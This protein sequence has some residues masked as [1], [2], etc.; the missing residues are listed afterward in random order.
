VTICLVTDRRRLAAGRATLA[1]A[2]ACLAAQARFAAEAGVDLVQVRER[3]LDAADLAAVVRDAIAATRGSRTRVVVNDRLDVALTCGADGVHLRGDSMAVEAARRIAPSGFL[4]GRSVH[5]IE[6][7]RASAAADY[8]IA[9]TVFPTPSKPG[10]PLL[11]IDGL[12]AIAAS[13]DV[14]VLGIGGITAERIA[15]VARTGA[16]GFAAIGA[17]IDASERAADCRAM[18]LRAWIDAVRPQFDAAKLALK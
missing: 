2:R 1:D 12:A 7:A 4:V 5:T 3:D 14:P 8:L 13:V 16:A 18:P 9:G 11:G 6:D 15:A 17:F 10:A